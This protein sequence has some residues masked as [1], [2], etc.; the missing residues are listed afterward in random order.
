MIVPPWCVQVARRK[1]ALHKH[2]LLRGVK[3][4]SWDNWTPLVLIGKK[5]RFWYE[6]VNRWEIV[7]YYYWE[8]QGITDINKHY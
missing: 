6:R 1:G 3:N 4:P 2:L 7:V 5:V 8:L